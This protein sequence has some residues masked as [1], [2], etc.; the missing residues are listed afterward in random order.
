MKFL[1]SGIPGVLRSTYFCDFVDF[2][3]KK[4]NS[5]IKKWTVNDFQVTLDGGDFEMILNYKNYK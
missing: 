2:E 3:G 1:S 5:N 4:K